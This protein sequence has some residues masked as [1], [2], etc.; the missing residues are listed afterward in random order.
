MA[1]GARMLVV[2]FVGGR[3]PEVKANYLLIKNLAV[4]GVRAGEYGRRDPVRSA[5]NVR[6]IDRLASSGVFRPHIGARLAIDVLGPVSQRRNPDHQLLDP[7]EEAVGQRLLRLDLFPLLLDLLWRQGRLPIGIEDVRMPAD[8]LVG[9]RLDRVADGEAAFL[10][11]DLREE[12]GSEE[13][14]AKL[15]LQR[16]V[17]AAVERV[18]QFVRFLQHERPQ[19]L[20]RLLLVPRA[21]VFGSQRA[22]DLDE[23][24]EARAGTVGHGP[25][26][27]ISF[28]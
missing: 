7:V 12:H 22:H 16:V 8:Q 13:K 14:I 26:A 10:G 18:E 3:I 19:R 1:W 23:A 17:V 6:E 5:E 27:S 21:A 2:G 15:V 24:I 20:Q 11:A 4:L 9:D 25:Y 28:L